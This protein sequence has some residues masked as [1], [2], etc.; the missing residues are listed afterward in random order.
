MANRSV[1]NSGEAADT[2]PPPARPRR[3][4]TVELAA[5]LLIVSGILQLIGAIG[6]ASFLPAGSEAVL[7]GSI[8]IN[9]ATIAAGVLIRSGRL[10]LL[11]VNYVAVLGFLDLLRSGSSPVALML[12]IADIVVVVILVQNRPWFVPPP[13]DEIPD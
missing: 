5:A 3:P 13:P 7:F 9:I 6:A 11:V 12:A 2:P 8:A 10:W 4:G 1:T